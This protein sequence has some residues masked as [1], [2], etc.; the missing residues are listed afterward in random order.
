MRRRSS[1]RSWSTSQKAGVHSGDAIMTIPTVSIS[2]AAKAK[3]REYTRAIAKELGVKG[4]FNIQ[5]LCVK[6]DVEVIECN[7]RASRS[8]PFVSK[9]TGAEPD[10]ARR[11][12]D[13]G[14]EAGGD[15]RRA[16]AKAVRGQGAAVLVHADGGRRA[17][18]RRGDA[19]DRR[20]G[21]LRQHPRRGDEQG[22]D[23]LGPQNPLEGGDWNN[24][25]GREVRA[26]R[27]EGLGRGVQEGWV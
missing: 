9:A 20:G 6:D 16:R 10:Q 7:L 22:A 21:V 13:P 12:G 18:G 4:P 27:G 26:G 3:I 15:G 24:P 5:Y 8:L 17:Y 25:R 1:G 2:E 23:S 14:R 11:P 19:L